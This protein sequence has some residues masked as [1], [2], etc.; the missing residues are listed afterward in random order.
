ML[1]ECVRAIGTGEM[2]PPA[3]ESVV[4]SLNLECFPSRKLKLHTAE[5]GGVPKAS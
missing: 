3:L 4:S 1:G 2:T 5:A